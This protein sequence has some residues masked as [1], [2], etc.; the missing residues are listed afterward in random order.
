MGLFL[1]L[2]ALLVRIKIYKTKN[3]FVFKIMRNVSCSLWL[4]NH[5]S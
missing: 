4:G 5:S 1:L 3:F 2:F